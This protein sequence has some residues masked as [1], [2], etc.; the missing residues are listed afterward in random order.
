ML[1][2]AIAIPYLLTVSV[3]GVNIVSLL[4]ERGEFTSEMASVTGTAFIIYSFGLFGHIVQEIFSRILYLSSRYKVTVLWTFGAVAA[5]LALDYILKDALGVYGI[6]LSTMLIITAYGISLMYSLYHTI[7]G[8]MTRETA[9][10]IGKCILS[11]AAAL[12][13]Y[14]IFRG[15][16]PNF[17]A[18]EYSFI[19]VSIICGV[20][21][22]AVMA[23]SGS[24]A[25]LLSA[26]KV[27]R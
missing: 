14:F 8:Y 2:S 27:A 7:G 18:G 4:Y 10:F 16:S 9:V 22:T 21:Y 13:V 25:K 23:A 12:A 17:A 24:A 15:V 6:A 5:N 19:A 3:Y 1:M 26:L 11:G 20:A